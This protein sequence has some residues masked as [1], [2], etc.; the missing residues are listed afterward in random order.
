LNPIVNPQRLG[1]ESVWE[2][3]LE[4]LE[5][6][7]RCIESLSAQWDEALGRLKKLVEK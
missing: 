4:K 7:R 2:L 1:R 5:A 3:D 6:A